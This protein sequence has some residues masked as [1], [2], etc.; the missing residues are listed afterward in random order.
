MTDKL[1]G[2]KE[3]TRDFLKKNGI[4][5]WDIILVKTKRTELEGI[6]LPRNE[7]ASPN[8]IELKLENN[9]NVGI[10]IAEVESIT[11]KGK[12][13]AKYKIP[14][15]KFPKNSDLPNIKLLG[16]GGTVA[17][18]LDYTTGAVIPSF[19]PGELFSA[20]PELADICN[21]DCEIVFEILS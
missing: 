15:K 17:S 20:V 8:Y 9:Y 19:T 3:T 1:E 18:R 21:L 2:Y 14:E 13:E 11:K 16:T 12:R 5:I 4:E 7:Y 10:S 6:L